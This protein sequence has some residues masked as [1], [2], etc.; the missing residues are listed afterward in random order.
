VIQEDAT[1]V[2]AGAPTAGQ[3]GGGAATVAR[4]PEQEPGFEG[5]PMPGTRNRQQTRDVAMLLDKVPF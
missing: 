5:E 2:A 1:A 3:D 4:L